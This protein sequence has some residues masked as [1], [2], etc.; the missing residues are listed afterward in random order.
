MKQCLLLIAV[1]V[2]NSCHLIGKAD[3]VSFEITNNSE[4]VI[5]D[6]EFYTSEKL[7]IV[8]IDNIQPKQTI[9]KVLQM[10]NNKTDGSYILKFKRKSG[11][12]ELYKN[13]YYTNGSPL[14]HTL[15]FNVKADTVIMQSSKY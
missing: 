14:E 2:L 12:E 4:N 9:S 8:N 7:E 13:G 10:K 1:C 5:S 15:S 6:I 3:S 11:K